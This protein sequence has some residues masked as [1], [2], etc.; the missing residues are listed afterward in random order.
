MNDEYKIPQPETSEVN[1]PA[2]AYCPGIRTA[3]EPWMSPAADDLDDDGIDWD[4]I[5]AP[6]SVKVH[7]MEEF[8]RKLDESLADLLAGRYTPHEEVW[9]EFLQEVENG[10]YGEI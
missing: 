6:E 3:A 2:V 1:E 10:E 7:S 5:G 9:R 4:S 8:K